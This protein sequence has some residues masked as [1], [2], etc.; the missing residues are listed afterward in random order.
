[1]K[2]FVL[3]SVTTKLDFPAIQLNH[4]LGKYST[5]ENIQRLQKEI[6][7][8][9]FI[10]SDLGKTN[11]KGVE[12]TNVKEAHRLMQSYN[13]APHQDMLFRF[14]TGQD[15][16]YKLKFRNYPPISHSVSGLGK[17]SHSRQK[18]IT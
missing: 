7:F 4:I 14:I 1:M 6:D 13:S 10:Q 15:E 8:S 2:S 5:G 17:E 11:G 3:T 16:G 12:W 9:Q 18:K